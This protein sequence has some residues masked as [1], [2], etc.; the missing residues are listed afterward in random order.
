VVDVSK[1]QGKAKGSDYV[2]LASRKKNIKGKIC[3]F[4]SDQLFMEMLG[5]P[6]VDVNIKQ[7]GR[8]T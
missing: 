2:A 4:F 6:V 1:A 5:I 8:I 7:G 3:S